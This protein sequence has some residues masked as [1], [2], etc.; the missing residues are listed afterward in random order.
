MD[1]L[2]VI[3]QLREARLLTFRDGFVSFDNYD[4]LAEFAQFDP[5]YLDQVGPL[6][7]L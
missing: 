5:T 7:P 6:L 3:E 1:G 4:P 2:S